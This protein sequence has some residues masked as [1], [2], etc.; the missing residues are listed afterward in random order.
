[1]RIEAYGKTADQVRL[2]FK[3]KKRQVRMLKRFAQTMKWPNLAETLDNLKRRDADSTAERSSSHAMAFFSGLVLP[4][5]TFPFLIMKSLID[6]D[7]DKATD[8]LRL[9]SHLHPQCGF[10]YR[11]SYTYWT[12]AS[13]VGKVLAPTC[14]AAAGWVGPARPTL[15]LG[16]N[17]IARIRS[18]PPRRFMTPEDVQSMQERSDPLG[19]PTEVFPVKEYALV[20]VDADDIV[21]TVRI[22]LLGLRRCG[23]R[24]GEHDPWLFDASVQFA[25]DGE[26][27]P[28][29]LSFDVSFVSSWPCS[30]GPHP[31][32]FDYGY[33]V[34]NVDELIDMRDWDG[35]WGGPGVET[36]TQSLPT[37]GEPSRW[38]DTAVGGRPPGRDPDDEKVLVVKAFGVKD[39]E[40][41]ARAWCS[42][43]GLSALVA[44]IERTW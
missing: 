36:S 40:V 11:N 32:F 12:G 35:S 10:Q 39:N 18:R 44:D 3:L 31:L 14:R 7:P 42:H 4:G 28:L 20:R 1:V 25:I 43:W 17:Q 27:W 22:E 21:D 41:L 37:N 26:S 33:L 23:D 19:P 29:K 24:A 9:L 38:K 8:D 2:R 15:D 34:A 6:M 13:I 30:Y 5:P 16:R